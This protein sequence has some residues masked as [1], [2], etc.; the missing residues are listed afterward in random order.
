MK[1][2]MLTDSE[3]NHYGVFD[4]IQGALI[5]SY[6]E[7]KYAEWISEVEINNYDSLRTYYSM[8]DISKYN[9]FDFNEL[10]KVPLKEFTKVYGVTVYFA[11][12]EEKE[13][14]LEYLE[15]FLYEEE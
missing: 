4:T 5:T 11:D 7:C 12:E 3:N 13:M 9:K 2:F 10:K 15:D 8:S 1:V 14:M 6:A